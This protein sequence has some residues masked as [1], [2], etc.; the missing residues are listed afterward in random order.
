MDRFEKSSSTQNV[1]RIADKQRGLYIVSLLQKKGLVGATLTYLPEYRTYLITVAKSEDLNKAQA[2]YRVSIGLPPPPP[3][4]TSRDEANSKVP[5]GRAPLTLILICLVI[6]VMTNFGS[7]SSKVRNLLFITEKMGEPLFVEVLSGQIWRLFTPALVHFGF[8]HLGLNML[9][10]K[11]LG[12]IQE[13][14]F[15]KTF[16]WYFV[17]ITA[18]ISNIAQYLSGGFLFGGMSGVIFAQLGFLWSYQRCCPEWP[19]GI[20]RE[21]IIGTVVWFLLCLFGVF[22]FKAANMAHAVGIA[23]GIMISLFL[24]RLQGRGISSKICFTHL[25][26]GVGVV[27]LTLV[28]EKI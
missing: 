25:G 22:F 15:G 21:A 4:Q 17:L 27:I 12:D 28:V 19:Y 23:A 13:H 5:T 2:I 24:C 1:G 9:C 20:S 3:L 8:L 10:F 7:I 18:F 6:F 14:A 26:L 11:Q 16:F